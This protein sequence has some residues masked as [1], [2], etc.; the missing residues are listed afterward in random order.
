MLRDDALDALREDIR[1][2]GIHD[3]IVL[4]DGKIL[5]GRN[6]FVCAQEL[7][8]EAPCVEFEGP[9]PLA[10]VVSHNLHRRHLT[11]S[12]RASVAARVANLRLGDNQ[13]SGGSANLQTLPQ[14]SQQD[15]ARMLNVSDRSVA[16]AKKVQDSAPPEVVWAL[17]EDRIS[18]SL[19]AKVASLPEELQADIIAAPDLRAAAREAVKPHV[20]Q[21]SGDNEWYTPAVFVEAARQVM[22][23][24]DLDPA[25][26]E[27]ANLT[28]RASQIFTAEVDGL[29]Q[30]WP[31]GRIWCN[32]PYASNLIGRFAARLAEAAM[33]GSQVIVLVNNATE[34]A[35]FQEIAAEC[36]AICFPK[37]RIRFLRPDGRPGA[38]L[39][40]QAILY[41]GPSAE[42][43][44]S[45]FAPFGLVVRHE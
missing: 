9:D 34:T 30:D 7:G 44:C 36:S 13:H 43:F 18:V 25:S 15:A 2:H 8:I 35:W 33:E 31:I 26:S 20:A 40:G 32:P 17:D 10:F 22:G 45:G 16:S 29:E 12:Q 24:I 38:P 11:E 28:V 23:G 3:P 14:V 21:N 27:I 42:K 41:S 4:F 37:T 1:Q 19:A 39:Q 5:D 6:R